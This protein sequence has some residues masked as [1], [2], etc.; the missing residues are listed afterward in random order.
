[1]TFTVE[2]SPLWFIAGIVLVIAILAG[3]VY[4]F[5]TYGRR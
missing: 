1:M 2:T 5:R 4:V 3:L